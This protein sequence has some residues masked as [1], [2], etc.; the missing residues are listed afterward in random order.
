[1]SFGNSKVYSTAIDDLC[2]SGIMDVEDMYEG[3]AQG[4]LINDK[5]NWGIPV[6][7]KIWLCTNKNI[8][9]VKFAD[10]QTPEYE[11]WENEYGEDAFWGEDS[12]YGINIVKQ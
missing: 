5:Y 7:S 10:I 12:E 11:K 9:I 1:M 8:L 4:I 6:G 2:S 3:T